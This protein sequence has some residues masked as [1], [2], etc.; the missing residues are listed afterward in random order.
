[1]TPWTPRRLGIDVGG[2]KC[3]GVVLDD[4]GD[5]RRRDPRA[6]AARRRRADRRRWPRSSPSSTAD[7]RRSPVGVGAPGLITLEGVLQSSP[8]V[9]DVTELD[10]AGGLGGRLGRPV[11]V[12]ND[13]TCAALAEWQ[14]GAGRG[15]TT[16]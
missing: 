3:L 5:G 2:T 10:V 4:G 7:G 16:W 14:R 9:P 1:M 15:S 11:A 8:N 12:G 13:A 6:D